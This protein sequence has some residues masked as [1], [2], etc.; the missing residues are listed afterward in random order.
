MEQILK[1]YPKSLFK[2]DPCDQKGSKRARPRIT[3]G[4]SEP[5]FFQALIFQ[6]FQV[7]FRHHFEQGRVLWDV[8]GN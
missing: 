5:I 7:P 6:C 3:G 4:V 8:P 2:D 1:L